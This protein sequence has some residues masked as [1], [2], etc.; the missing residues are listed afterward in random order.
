MI[1]EGR[2]GRPS[3]QNPSTGLSR[4]SC[5]RK[6]R[7]RRRR[8][9]DASDT[10]NGNGRPHHQQPNRR[11]QRNK[12]RAKRRSKQER[13]KKI[14]ILQ[15]NMAGLKTRK[16]E[17][18]HRLSKLDIDIAVISECNFSVKKDDKTGKV[19]HVIPELSGWNVE[20]TPRQV[21][22]SVGSDSS[23]RGGVA[24]LIKEGFNYQLSQ[25]SQYQMAMLQLNLLV[26]D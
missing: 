9:R 2:A 21:G 20:A 25:P 5:R 8:R 13:S 23:G 3:R 1:E 26:S 12:A 11:T 4:I 10:T 6:K 16:T 22:R 18:L 19:T 7:N 15:Q 17:L 24:I 14:R